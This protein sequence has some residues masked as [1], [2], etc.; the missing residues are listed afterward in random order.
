MNMTFCCCFPPPP[1]PTQSWDVA[2]C[3]LE[4]MPTTLDTGGTGGT[5]FQ[6][7]M[8]CLIMATNRGVKHDVASQVQWYY[9]LENSFAIRAAS[10]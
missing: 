8:C 5:M 9:G 4:Y 3:I 7:A 6:I 10:R 2:L 1:P